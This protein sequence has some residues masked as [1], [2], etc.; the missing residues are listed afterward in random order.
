M[1]PLPAFPPGP[2]A[3][4][5]R[6][7]RRVLFAR[8]SK[9]L[10]L[11]ACGVLALVVIVDRVVVYRSI[12][13]QAGDG[14]VINLAGRQRMLSQKLCKAALLLVNVGDAVTRRQALSE[15]RETVEMSARS[16][17]VLQKGATDVHPHNTPAIQA[18]YTSLQPHHEAMLRAVRQLMENLSRSES[19]TAPEDWK[20]IETILREEPAF[21]ACMDAIVKH[22]ELEDSRGLALLRRVEFSLSA[23]LLLTL[24]IEALLPCG[25]RAGMARSYRRAHEQAE[26]PTGFR[27]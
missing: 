6:R 13:A 16:H 11:T 5:L 15:L 21:L 8:R 18:L 4:L 27:P 1:A 17:E 26:W 3:N 2:T 14:R 10:Y 7:E 20:A 19:A 25:L 24:S 12:E 23:L 22:Y 9:K